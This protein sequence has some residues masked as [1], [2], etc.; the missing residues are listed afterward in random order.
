MDERARLKKKQLLN[1][2]HSEM[3]L[4]PG[5]K[6]GKVGKVFLVFT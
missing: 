2:K 3:L 4:L 1:F 5:Q 6:V